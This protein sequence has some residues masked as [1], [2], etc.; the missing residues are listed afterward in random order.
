MFGWAV[1][2]SFHAY[3]VFVNDGVLGKSWEDKKIKEMMEKEN[4]HKDYR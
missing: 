1:G 3:K 4:K 2:L